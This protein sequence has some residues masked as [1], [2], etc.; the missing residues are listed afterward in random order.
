M[1]R[2][3][4]FSEISFCC[5]SGFFAIAFFALSE[6]PENISLKQRERVEGFFQNPEETVWRKH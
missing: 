3:A 4:A 6:L 5:P 2:S 1:N